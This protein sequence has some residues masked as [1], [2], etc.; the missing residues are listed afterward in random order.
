MGRLTEIY[1]RRTLYGSFS[2]YSLIILKGFDGGRRVKTTKKYFQ[3]K[4]SSCTAVFIS[5]LSEKRKRITPKKNV[6]IKY[7]SH[8]N[9]SETRRRSNLYHVYVIFYLKKLINIEF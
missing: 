1:T 9:A 6:I 2:G 5:L 4:V 7:E 3:Q 8:R